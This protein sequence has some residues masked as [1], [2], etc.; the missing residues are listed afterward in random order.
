GR[1]LAHSRLYVLDADFQPV[2]VGVPGE[3][4]IGGAQVTRGYLHRPELTA[5]RYVPDLY[6]PTPGARMYRSGDKVRWREDGRVEF[7]GRADFQVKVRGFRVEPGEVA[8]VLREHPEVRDAVVLAREDIPGDKR[9]VA[10]VVPAVDV[11][12]LRSWLRE[13]LPEHMVPSAFV[14]L[15]ALPLTPNGKVD[16]KALP[17]PVMNTDASATF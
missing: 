1:P 6:S 7:I 9:L 15:E 4:F 17:A 3:L 2:P 12:A 13:R 10:Y 11:A 8:T 16:R 14:P 5:E